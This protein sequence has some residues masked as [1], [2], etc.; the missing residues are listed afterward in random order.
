DDEV[1][2]S[3]DQGVNWT[4]NGTP[5]AGDALALRYSPASASRAFFITDDGNV[6]YSSDVNATTCVG[7][8][9]NTITVGYANPNVW[10]HAQIAA[11]PSNA[12]K[13]YLAGNFSKLWVVTVG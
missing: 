4:T 13:V 2:C 5:G 11:S 8:H 3:D 6:Q 1:L 7:V 12:N 10:T 9:W